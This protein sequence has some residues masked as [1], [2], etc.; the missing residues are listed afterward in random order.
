MRG[1]RIQQLESL[2]MTTFDAR[3]KAVVLNTYIYLLL[4]SIVQTYQ[5]FQL[6]CQNWEKVEMKTE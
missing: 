5:S 1:T 2:D 6:L 4:F 3:T